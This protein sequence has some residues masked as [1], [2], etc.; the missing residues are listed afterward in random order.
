[1][2]CKNRIALNT[3]V[4]FGFICIFLRIIH[5]SDKDDDDDNNAAVDDGGDVDGVADSFHLECT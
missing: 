5:S 4:C 3:F 2:H 1:M